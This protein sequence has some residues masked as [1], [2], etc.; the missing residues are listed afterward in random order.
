MAQMSM[1][2]AV[3]IVLFVAMYALGV[4]GQ[5]FEMVPAPAP[6]T[7][8][9]AAAYSFRMSGPMICSSLMLSLLALLLNH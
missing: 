9:G 5:D 7:D 8:K 3:A 2:K 4:R 1:F 6:T